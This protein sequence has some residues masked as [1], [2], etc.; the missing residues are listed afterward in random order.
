MLASTLF[1]EKHDLVSDLDLLNLVNETLF[2]FMR[3]VQDLEA[4]PRHPNSWAQYQ[5]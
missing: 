4:H 5:G 3:H 2:N 1:E